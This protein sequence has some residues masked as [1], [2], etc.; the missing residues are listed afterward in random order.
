MRYHFPPGL[1]MVASNKIL[2]GKKWLCEAAP[3]IS[4]SHFR[5]YKI[6]DMLV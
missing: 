2:E 4:V 1:A 3:Y 5:L 6:T